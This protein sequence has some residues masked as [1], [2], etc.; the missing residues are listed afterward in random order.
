MVFGYTR[1][2]CTRKEKTNC[3]DISIEIYFTN[4]RFIHSHHHLCVSVSFSLSCSLRVCVKSVCICI[5][6]F[7]PLHVIVFVFFDHRFV[8]TYTV[9]IADTHLHCVY[10]RNTSLFL[11]FTEIKILTTNIRYNKNGRWQFNRFHVPLALYREQHSAI[12]PKSKFILNTKQKTMHFVDIFLFTRRFLLWNESSAPC[13]LL[14][15][16]FDVIVQVLR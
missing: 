1:E 5:C 3:R 10:K 11:R 2:W 7:W 14:F 9:W 13:N 15:I 4:M 8:F 16:L 12:A 6:M